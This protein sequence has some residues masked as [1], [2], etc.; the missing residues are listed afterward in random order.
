MRRLNY[1][2]ISSPF[3]FTSLSMPAEFFID[4]FEKFFSIMFIDTPPAAVRNSFDGY[5]VSNVLVNKQGDWRV[6]VAATG[7]V[8]NEIDIEIDN[9]VLVIVGKKMVHEVGP[10][11][12]LDPN[13]GYKA[14]HSKLKIKDF[15]RRFQIPKELD[16]EL[17]KAKVANGLLIVDIPIKHDALP[18]TRKVKINA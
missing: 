3:A 11:Q 8:D 4:D 15:E 13:E 5:P 12:Y 14:I 7:F 10:K 6:E 1:P 9:N 18:K 2:Q 17:A 16:S